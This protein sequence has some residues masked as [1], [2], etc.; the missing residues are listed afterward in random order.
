MAIR[1]RKI[2]ILQGHPDPQGGHFGHALAAAYIEGAGAAG[3][4]TQIIPIATLTF[5]LLRNRDQLE[6]EPAPDAIRRVQCVMLAADHV[7]LFDPVWNGGPPALV[8]AF[9]EQTFRPAFTFPDAKAGEARGFFSALKQRKALQGKTAR[10]V[11]DASVRL[12]M[13]LP[14]TSGKEHAAP[15]RRQSSQGKSDRT[16]GRSESPPTRTMAAHDAPTRL[17]RP[18]VPRNHSPYR[19]L[20]KNACVAGLVGAELEVGT[21][22]SM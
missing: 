3:H 19:R 4:Q 18:L 21:G 9:L 5:P 11:A 6:H 8:R 2:L 14:S 7:V 12:S 13:V 16:R 10:I 17:A 22:R 20:S 15:Q 1:V